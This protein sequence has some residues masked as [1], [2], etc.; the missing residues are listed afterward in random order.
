MYSCPLIVYE[1]LPLPQ[2]TV[3]ICYLHIL[4]SLLIFFVRTPQLY[5][6]KQHT[7]GQKELSTLVLFYASSSSSHSS[8]S[9]CA[10]SKSRNMD[11]AAQRLLFVFANRALPPPPP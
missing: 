5:A 1:T 9:S 8:I 11:L 3:A 6:L 10:R 4:I 2:I 7:F